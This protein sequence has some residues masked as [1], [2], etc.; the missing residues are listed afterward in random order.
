MEET[1]PPSLEGGVVHCAR[2]AKIK[3]HT[4]RESRAQTIATSQHDTEKEEN[5]CSVLVG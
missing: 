5:I 1:Y 3:G 4:A 2:K